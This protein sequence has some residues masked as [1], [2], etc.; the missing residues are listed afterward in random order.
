[1]ARRVEAI[2]NRT[3][4]AGLLAILAVAALVRF[5]KL[6]QQD[7]WLDELHSM[8]NS[9]GRRAE[10]EAI[11]FG[12]IIQSGEQPTELR[13]GSTITSVWT[14]MR[15][16]SHPPV[17]FLLLWGWRRLWGDGEAAIRSLPVVFSVLSLIPVAL[18]FRDFQRAATGL[19]AALLLS[20]S[21]T[22]VWMAQENRPYSLSILLTSFGYF[23]LVRGEA[24]WKDAPRHRKMAIAVLYGGSLYLALLTHYF[25]GLVILGQG[26]YAILRFRGLTLR[27]WLVTLFI[28]CAGV[29][30]TW[31]GSFVQQLNFIREQPWLLEQT[32]DHISRTVL[33]LCDLPIRLMVPRPRFE[34]TLEQSAIGLALLGCCIG[35]WCRRRSRPA[36]LFG[37]WYG[38]P[39]I[40]FLLIDLIAG[41]QILS[42]LRYSVIAV[43]GL[44]G[45]I[46]VAVDELRVGIRGGVQFG[47]FAIAVL[48][49]RLP[50]ADNPRAREA[51]ALLRS[52]LAANDLVVY[53][54]IG[55]PRDWVP[56]F[57]VPINYYL[58]KTSSPFLLLR[59]PPS[60]EVQNRISTYPRIFVV[61][62]RITRLD[63][64]PNPSPVT[65]DLVSQSDY[66]DQIGWIYLFAFKEPR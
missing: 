41:K 27:W 26:V 16:D 65:H 5:Y 6:G 23:F 46:S 59:D 25:S 54:A 32:P 20:L 51:A 22:H 28:S 12:Q 33:R 56:Q 31:G 57:F 29:V 30:F 15:H 39:M 4:A 49:A 62:P 10:L 66:I 42:H 18:I 7:F 11:P 43:P 14:T 61:S 3:F 58:G 21:H 8:A 48:T 60:P 64:F 1:M 36:M 40:A 38:L 53:D 47:I 55:W 37:L 34:R 63:G 19:F 2:T 44:V 35:A 9:A 50:A 45:L 52:R 24:C 17:Y 13:D